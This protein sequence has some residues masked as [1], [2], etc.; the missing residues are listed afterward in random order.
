MAVRRGGCQPVGTA[1]RQTD[2]TASLAPVEVTLDADTAVEQLYAAHWRR[3]VRLA[4]L[5]LRDQG[6][7]EE[8]VHHRSL[9][10]ASSSRRVADPREA[11]ALTE[12][13]L[14]PSVSAI[15]ASD[16]SR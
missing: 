7:A 1:P 6:A 9:S 5:L 10:P 8:V 3:L 13:R 12:P 11:C 4:V 2:V 16:S 15:S 14:M